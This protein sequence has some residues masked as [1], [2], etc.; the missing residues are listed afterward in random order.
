[1][2]TIKITL[3]QEQQRADGKVAADFSAKHLGNLSIEQHQAGISPYHGKA[4]KR[5]PT[6]RFALGRN[7]KPTSAV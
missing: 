1:M 5:L 6:D 3:Q 2:S 7:G 4:G